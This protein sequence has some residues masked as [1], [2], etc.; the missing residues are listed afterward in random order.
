LE[1]DTEAKRPKGLAI[2]GR[3]IV[4]GLA[5]ALIGCGDGD[6]TEDSRPPDPKL[7][8]AAALGE[9]IFNDPGLSASGRI[10]CAT[11]H[12][13]AT[14]HATGNADIVVP[15]GGAAGDVSGFRNAPS[16][17]YLTLNPAFF[18]DAEGTPRGG[19][20]RD[21]RAASLAEQAQRPFLAALEMANA[22]VEAVIAKLAIAPYVDEFRRVFGAGILNTPDAAFDRMRLALARY[23]R[24][25]REFRPFDS[26]YDLFVTGRVSLTGRELQGLALFNDPLKGNCAACH[27]SGR[28]GD[29]SPPLFTDF[30]YD[31]IGVPRN[32]AIAANADPEYFDRGLCGPF[33]AD[34]AERTDLCGAFKVPHTAQR[35]RHGALLPQ[36][37]LQDAEGSRR[38]LRTPRYQSRGVVSAE[39]GRQRWKVRR[40]AAGVPRQRQH[41][42]GA[43]RPQGR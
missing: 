27:P 20:N 17:R 8:A 6:G 41:D 39:A 31:N 22:T 5:V 43:V 33:R 21:G 9:K 10:S 15:A 24:E 35:R 40:P 34:L 29:G 3:L 38:L 37:P 36:R 32:P 12:D 7:S 13:P 1:Q 19:F 4:A 18:F 2:A 26:K 16:L 11:C 23:Q 30:T 25:D 28:G 14:A 42:R